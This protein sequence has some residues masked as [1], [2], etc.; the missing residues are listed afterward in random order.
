MPGLS[1]QAEGQR[2]EV[3]LI[4]RRVLKARMR[5]ATIVEVQVSANRTAGLPNAVI[6]F[7]I[8]FLVFDAAPKPLDEDVVAPGA[9]AVHAN[10]NAIVGEDAGER[11]A[12][13]LRAL[14]G[15]DDV[16]LSVTSQG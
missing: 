10:R 14:I 6:G 5:P 7:E 8:H 12:G 2:V 13:E 11:L 15:V 4:G 3:G 9:F 16:R 1:C